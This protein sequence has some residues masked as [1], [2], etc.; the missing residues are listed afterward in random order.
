MAQ[1][2]EQADQRAPRPARR[3]RVAGAQDRGAQVL[4][5]LVIEGHEGQQREIA[6]AVV[7]PVEE[8]ELLRAVGR[9]IGGVEVDR[10]PPGAPMEPLP[11][12]VDHGRGEF[13]AHRVEHARA[14]PRFRSARSWVARRAE[15]PSMGSRPSSSL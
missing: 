4:L 7:M 3:G 15:S 13:A 11:M 6:P 1:Q 5:D 12:A 2:I 9:V 14:R 10:D 8:G